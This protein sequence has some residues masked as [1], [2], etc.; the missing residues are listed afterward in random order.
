MAKQTTSHP[1]LYGQ[2]RTML[3]LGIVLALLLSLGAS[4]ALSLTQ[5]SRTRDQALISA[6]QVAANAPT[7]MEKFDANQIADYSR[8]TVVNVSSVDV[9][10]VYDS[11]GTAI[12]F[13][14]LDSGDDDPSELQP[15]SEYVMKYFSKGEDTLLYNGE[16][17]LGTDR[18]AYAAVYSHNGELIGFAMA[19]IYMRSIRRIVLRM[20]LFHLLAGIGALLIGGF[21]SLHLSR[22]IKDEL[23]GYEPDVFRKLFL[24]RTDI[25]DALEEGM[26]AIDAQSRVIYLNRAASD[27]LRI[28][29]SDALG[30]PLSS[31][32][33]R[34]TIA[35][36]MQ[37]GR[38]EYNI[39]LESIT[40]VSVISDR[41]PLWR[42]GEI[43]GA[44]AIF[45]NRTEATKLAQDLTGVQHIVEALRAYTHEF[46]N[47]LHVILGLLQLGETK[48]AEEYVLSITQTRVQSIDYISDRI[49]DP[50]VAALLIG[51]AYRAAE[52][53]IR[54]TLDPSSVLHGNGQYM[55]VSGLITV[56]GNLIENAFDAMRTAPADVPSEVTVSIREGKHALLLSVDDTGPGISPEIRNQIFRRGFSTKGEGRGTG[57]ALVHD[58]IEAY[59]GSIRVESE[60]GVGTSFI[61]TLSDQQPVENSVASSG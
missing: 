12:A 13:Y 29:Q 47:K 55:P 32:Y 46:T 36:V 60:L 16:A 28:A 11:S 5:E 27:M 7:L 20:I 37:T 35:R 21:L 39:S 49:R 18:C 9:F 33:P 4:F 30:Q 52:L 3:L 50:S 6:A 26:L 10:A 58:V 25:L 15:L 57:L 59:H 48:R 31:I 34:S 45:R 19:G 41:I 1:D 38:A 54:F 51:K 8:R 61:I 44:I 2:I 43:E 24:Q 56:L 42:D 40:H 53:N 22:R 23:L 17:P 14:D